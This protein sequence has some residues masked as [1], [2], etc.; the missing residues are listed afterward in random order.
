MRSA[1]IFSCFPSKAAPDAAAPPP[2]GASK[3]APDAATPAGGPQTKDANVGGGVGGDPHAAGAE[4]GGPTVGE[5]CFFLTAVAACCLIPVVAVAFALMGEKE[6]VG[7]QS[8]VEELL[9]EEVAQVRST[10][11]S[12]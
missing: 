6:A 3:A 4:A 8:D 2:D 1:G 5:S 12:L 11:R 10:S 9:R 7:I